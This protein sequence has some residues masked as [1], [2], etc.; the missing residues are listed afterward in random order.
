M[1]KKK[2]F[3]K[4]GMIALSIA[5]G[6]GVIKEA[7]VNGGKLVFGAMLD[8]DSDEQELYVKWCDIGQQLE[9]NQTLN[10]EQRFAALKAVVTADM[11]E[12]FGE[13]PKDRD[14]MHA[15]YTVVKDIHGDFV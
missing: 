2:F 9:S 5:P 11:R 15:V 3:A 10:N 4:L 6:G 13:D 8:D 12:H 14:V 7:I 1:S